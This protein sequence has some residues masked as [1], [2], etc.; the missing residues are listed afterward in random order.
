MITKRVLSQLYGR[1]EGGLDHLTDQK[2]AR[3][4]TLCKEL[5]ETVSKI[6]PGFSQFRGLSTW[7][8]FLARNEQEKRKKENNGKEN[9]LKDLLLIVILCLQMENKTLTPGK[10]C[11]QARQTMKQMDS[12][13]DITSQ[14]I[15]RLFTLITEP[16]KPD[17]PRVFFEITADGQPLGRIT[18]ELRADVVPR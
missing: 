14:D 4:A 13:L 5:L 17:N 10:V 16:Q 6:D 9:D 15:S 3:K 18:M 12:E 7:E 2:L 11:E 1:G 8:L